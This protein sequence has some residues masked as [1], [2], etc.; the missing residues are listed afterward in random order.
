MVKE[1]LNNAE[2]DEETMNE[3][4][5]EEIRFFQ[6]KDSLQAE[7]DRSTLEPEKTD[8]DVQPALTAKE[9]CRALGVS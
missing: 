1:L 7:N 9:V 8:D 2:E 6:T 3:L 5:R 4:I